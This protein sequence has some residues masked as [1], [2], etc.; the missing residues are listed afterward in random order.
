MTGTDGEEARLYRKIT[1]PFF[2]EQTMHR[3][4]N[5]SLN[6]TEVLCRVL[7]AGQTLDGFQGELRQVLARMTLDILNS[8]CF[9]GDD[10]NC[11]DVLR[12]QEQIPSDHQ[13][14]YFQAMH[15][16]L[17][18]FTTIFFTPIRILSM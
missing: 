18:H 6:S 2:T 10:Q 5:K 11:L 4:W 15:T 1:A 7:M 16:M 13:M 8:V 9:E 17:D 3:V 12:F 14:S